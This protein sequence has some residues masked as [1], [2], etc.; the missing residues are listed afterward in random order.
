M[1]K[2]PALFYDFSGGMT[3]YPLDCPPNKFALGRN[4]LIVPY[5][6]TGKLFTRSGSNFYSTLANAQIPPGPQRIG[7]VR[8]F[9]SIFF[10][11]SSR[12]LYWLSTTWQTLTGPTGNACFP[13]T[14]GTGNVYSF[15][16]WNHMLYVA[17]DNFSKPQKIYR[18]GSGVLQLRTAGLPYVAATYDS[19]GV[20]LTP[21][22]TASH[23]G[24]AKSFIYTFCY[25]YDYTVNTLLYQDIGPLIQT[26]KT[27]MSD[28]GISGHKNTV[29]A[30]P[31]LSNGATD[32]YATTQIKVEIY[33]TPHAGFA[34]Y[35][36][37]EVTNGTT[38]FDDTVSDATLLLN[39]PLYTD[40][41]VPENEPPPLCKIVHV[42]ENTGYF[43]H[44]MDG[45]E[46]FTNRIRQ[47]LDGDIDSSPSDYYVDVEAEIVG[48]SSA[49]GR[50]IVCCKNG[51]VFR[52]DGGVNNVGQGALMRQ[53]ISDTASCVS[54]QSLVQTLD[55]VFWAGEDGIYCTDGYQ[56]IKVNEDMDKTWKTF[57]QTD[58][59]KKR[60]QGKYDSTFRR[61]YWTIQSET[62]GDVDRCLVLDLNWGIS[63]KMPF[64][65][66]DGGDSFAPTSIEFSKG[67]LIRADRRGFVFLHDPAVYSDLR[68]DTT[69]D[70]SEWV[71]Q[72]IIYHY[73]SG[74]ASFG[75]GVTRKFVPRLHLQCKNETNLSL[76]I[77]SNN[78][79]GRKIAPMKPIRYRGNFVWGDPL[80]VWGDLGW[81]WDESGLIERNIRF[82]ARSLRC[83][84]KQIEMTNAVVNLFNS[85]MFGTVTVDASARTAILDDGDEVWPEEM[86]GYSI[87]FESDGYTVGFPITVASDDTLQFNDPAGQARDRT[88]EKFQIKGQ[89]KDEIL[90]LLGYTYEFADYSDTQKGY[91]K[92]DSGGLAE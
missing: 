23:P 40:A 18:D 46:I 51:L 30:I 4:L 66:L 91:D 1:D 65:Y 34:S 2:A 47:S 59:Q 82:P 79:D 58:D 27:A 86:E 50:P 62:V 3:D 17:C 28:P 16:E 85:D 48:M 49:Q 57:V 56:V 41:G 7:H 88:G 73:I 11:Q 64:T 45:T 77:L 84:V 29:T 89:P 68:V 36:V 39:A 78:D 75:T 33:R 32:N 54:G 90:H 44:V 60:I 21:T 43:A 15:A 61:I 38:T 74:G 92:A 83:S 81:V 31:V 71:R 10:A 25:R 24:D 87:Y 35:K 42:V 14:V 55:R 19:N 5:G 70:P 8:F 69:F 67:N 6:Q 80:F 22:I 76:Q 12:N 53:R 72:A 9:E 13:S 63:T 37:G 20:M 52:L 26:R